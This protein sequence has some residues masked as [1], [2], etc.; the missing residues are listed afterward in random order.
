MKLRAATDADVP[1]IAALVLAVASVQAPWASYLPARQR[2]DPVLVRH[3]EAVVRGHV[4]AGEQTSVVMVAEQR[5][6]SG[7]LGRAEIVSV[8][9][10]D[11][12]QTVCGRTDPTSCVRED[13]WAP[14][15]AEDYARLVALNEAMNKGRRRYFAAEGQPHVY[16]RVLATHP[17]HQGRG[18][19]KALCRWGIALARRARVGVCLETG[20]R[21]YIM[22]SGMGFEDLGAVVV[23]AGKGHDEQVLKV[24]GMDAAAVQAANPGVWNS[25]WKY[26]ST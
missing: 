11:T 18:H 10:W 6:A 8:A 15:G 21:G 16:L 26:L 25:L 4:A 22:L 14:R 1:A 23:P 24:L 2:R 20:S 3:A 19:A 9:V 5:C 17:D 13:E 7:E 12:T